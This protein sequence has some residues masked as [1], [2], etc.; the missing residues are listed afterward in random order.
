MSMGAAVVRKVGGPEVI[1]VLEVRTSEPGS[2]PDGPAT[3]RDAT[4]ANTPA[5]GGPFSREQLADITALSAL[6]GRE[7]RRIR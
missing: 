3:A 4:D 5:E 2:R 1:E 7:R 6:K